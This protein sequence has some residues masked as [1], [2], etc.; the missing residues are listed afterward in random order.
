MHYRTFKGDKG[1]MLD[2]QS[3]I[4]KFLSRKA[5]FCE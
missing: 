2:I 5:F 3:Q 4:Y 1:K